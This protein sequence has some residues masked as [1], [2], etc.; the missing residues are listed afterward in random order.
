MKRVIAIFF[1]LVG[2]VGFELSNPVNCSV[3]HTCRRP[4]KR[5]AM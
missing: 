3:I 5:R 1:F 4:E 2:G